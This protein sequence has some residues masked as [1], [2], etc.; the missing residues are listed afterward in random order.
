GTEIK[1]QPYET[2]LINW[3]REATNPVLTPVEQPNGEE[4]GTLYNGD[5]DVVKIGD[6]WVMFY[7]TDTP[8]QIGDKVKPN[9]VI[10]SFAVSKDMV[11]WHK[12]DYKLTEKNTTY[13]RS[14]A[15]KTA[16]VKKNGVVYHYY[17]AVAY[18][19][20]AMS[21]STPVDRS[22]V[23]EAKDITQDGH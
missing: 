3:E 10:D 22:R 13:A 18:Q 1:I 17:N 6:Y 16:V 21:L 15:H 8:V 4:W 20:R 19:E 9:N 5:A 7:F 2:D 14:Y 12:S 11:N 23:M